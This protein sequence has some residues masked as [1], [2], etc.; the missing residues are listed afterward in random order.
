[1]FSFQQKTACCACHLHPNSFWFAEIL[2]TETGCNNNMILLTP[3]RPTGERT[4]SASESPR[5]AGEASSSVE[6]DQAESD[7]S[8]S[9]YTSES[10][11]EESDS[12]GVGVN[13]PRSCIERAV[14][15]LASSLNYTFED[16]PPPRAELRAALSL[17]QSQQWNEDN[18]R[19]TRNNGNTIPSN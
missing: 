19:G 14:D 15:I 11:H 16:D 6:H 10:E 13:E 18:E 9:S 4:A 17:R 7:D 12:D 2:M 3:D 5:G 8:D 1:M